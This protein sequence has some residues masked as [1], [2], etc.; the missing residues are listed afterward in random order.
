MNQFNYNDITFIIP[1]KIDYIERIRNAIL[2]ISFLSKIHPFRII[3]K[4]C[5][6]QKKL[7]P[8]LSLIKNPNVEYI[9]E[10][11]KNDFFHRTKLLNDMILS[12]NTSIICN[13]DCDVIL[14]KRNIDKSINLFNS[15]ADVVYP[16][17]YGRNQQRLYSYTSSTRSSNVNIPL[18]KNEDDINEFIKKFENKECVLRDWISHYGHCVFVKTESYIEGFMEN[19]LFKSYGPE[20][21]ERFIRFKK[22]GFDVKHLNNGDYVHHLEHPRGND[23][24]ESNKYFGFNKQLYEYLYSL[25]KEELFEFYKTIPYVKERNLC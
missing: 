11:N 15:G 22:F 4:E 13:F 3:I 1:I 14:E 6:Y 9:F 24:G 17:G 5:D 19:E 10:E 8:Y 21:G 16:Y 7:E 25:S 23:S 12:A 20:D 2:S 18:P